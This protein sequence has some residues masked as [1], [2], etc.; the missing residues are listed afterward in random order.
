MD[1]ALWGFLGTLVG[2]AAS[3]LAT[4]LSAKYAAKSQGEAAANERAIREQLLQRETLIEFQNE[5]INLLR[6]NAAIFMDYMRQAQQGMVWSQLVA[7]VE[8]DEA[9]RRAFAQVSVLTSRITTD[10]IRSEVGKV[11]DLLNKALDANDHVEADRRHR[12]AMLAGIELI[13]KVGEE[14]RRCSIAV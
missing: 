4:Y 9:V 10:T 2:A 7:S 6:A 12:T 5:L 3:F 8:T 14:I 1:A 11:R 13:K